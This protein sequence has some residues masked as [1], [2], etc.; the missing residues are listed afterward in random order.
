MVLLASG[1][2][3]PKSGP[4]PEWFPDFLRYMAQMRMNP[5]GELETLKP[6][7]WLALRERLRSVL[8]A[9]ASADTPYLRIL[10]RYAR[11]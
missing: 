6:A 1:R 8:H 4:S 9:S 5:D 10:R 7:D 3:G 11:E 2:C